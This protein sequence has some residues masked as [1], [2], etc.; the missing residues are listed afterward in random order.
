MPPRFF[1]PG[2]DAAG[3]VVTLPEDEAQHLTRVLR[4]GPGDRVSVFNGHGAEFDS[5]VETI[6]RD[7]VSVRL[8]GPR[9]PAPEPALKVTI[10]QAVL[11]GERMDDVVRDAVMIGAAAIRPIV[12]ERTEV[13]LAT[14]EKG[15]R[16]E[17]WERIAVSS[18]KQCGRAVVPPIEAPATLDALVQT[19]LG[20]WLDG[21]ALLF[22]EPAASGA[23]VRFGELDVDPPKAVTLVIGPEGGWTAQEIE[24]A[25]AVCRPVVMGGRTIRADAMAVVALAALF[26]KWGEF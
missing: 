12:T 20:S 11:K 10:A 16:R 4:L 24:S 17:R 21:P 1:A 2:A 6:G 14:L 26:A 25:C 19:L 3:S 9:E 15:R 8:T 13:S 23:G 7:G 18:A 22:V 5:L